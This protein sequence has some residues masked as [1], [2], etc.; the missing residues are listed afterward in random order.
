MFCSTLGWSAGEDSQWASLAG[1]VD[2]LWHYLLAECLS[3]WD[4]CWF[5]L[6]GVGLFEALIRCKQRVNDGLFAPGSQLLEVFICFSNLLV[7]SPGHVIIISKR[8][9]TWAIARSPSPSKNPNRSN[10]QW[11]LLLPPLP[12]LKKTKTTPTSPLHLNPQS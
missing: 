7:L 6:F 11:A 2:R 5:E 8:E 9:Q 1:M 10:N 3:W 4:L 12:P